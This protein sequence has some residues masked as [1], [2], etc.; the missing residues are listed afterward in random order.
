MKEILKKL[1]KKENEDKLEKF[2]L[3]AQIIKKQRKKFKLTLNKASEGIC[4]V[5]YLSKMENN[6]LNNVEE[7][8]MLRLCDRMNVDYK[9]IVSGDN[10]CSMEMLAFCYLKGDNTKIKEFYQS[11]NKDIDNVKTDL[12]KGFYYLVIKDF[13]GLNEIIGSIYEVSSTMTSAEYFMF[14]ILVQE[15]Y[16]LN[17]KMDKAL[18]TY[19]EL[20]KMGCRF[21]LINYLIAYQGLRI[22]F[23]KNDYFNFMKCYCKIASL[24][25][26]VLPSEIHEV[27]RL[28]RACI[29]VKYG[30][31]YILDSEFLYGYSY[32]KHYDMEIKYLK[33]MLLFNLGKYDIVKDF[34]REQKYEQL[35]FKVLEN[36]A[37]F[38]SGDF[39][40]CETEEV[41]NNY[42]EVFNMFLSEYYMVKSS[43]LTNKETI[44]VLK[45]IRKFEDE[46]QHHLYNDFIYAVLSSL[47]T[48]STL[49]KESMNY[50]KKNLN[51]VIKCGVEKI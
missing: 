45:K 48:S 14:L 44:A 16:I 13:D 7:D 26:I 4:S 17:F 21:R 19:Y 37:A 3:F 39:N 12:I 51:R 33:L 40:I 24:H 23:H 20:D 42:H 10:L 9:S 28:M 49:Y 27:S 35:R 5:S 8:F 29:S 34:I 38:Y 31:E 50:L 30:E 2:E 18:E 6:L 25:D 1:N 22:F 11:I 15:Y 32:N 47:Y 46:Y 36:F 43:N 41:S